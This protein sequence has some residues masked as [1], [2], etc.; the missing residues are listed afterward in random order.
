MTTTM[1][2]PKTTFLVDDREL[3]CLNIPTAKTDRKRQR[4]RQTEEK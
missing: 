2:I 1:N 4:Q 3:A